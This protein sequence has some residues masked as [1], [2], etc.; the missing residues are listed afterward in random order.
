MAANA[1]LQA[2][3]GGAV[4]EEAAAVPTSMGLTISDA[5]RLPLTRIAQ[6]R[7]IC[8]VGFCE[9]ATENQ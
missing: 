2:R 9:I 7:A 5:V 6:D 3:I 1:L 4:K 8:A